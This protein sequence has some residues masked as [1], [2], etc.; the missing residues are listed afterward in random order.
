MRRIN[1]SEMAVAP[2]WNHADPADDQPDNGDI[3]RQH[4]QRELHESRERGYREGYAQ[5]EKKARD[6]VISEADASTKRQEQEFRR[7]QGEL[8]T[9]RKRLDML[10]DSLSSALE[11]QSHQVEEVAVGIAYAAVAKF[12]GDRY[13]DRDLM[14]ALVGH[15]LTHV[16]E[17]V[18]SVHVS[19]QDFE[20]VRDV[21]TVRIVSDARLLPGQCTLETR[22]GHY[23]TGLD[24]RLELL[25][26]A[27][28]SGL[29]QHRNEERKP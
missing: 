10:F 18:D 1:S 4:Q 22:L 20:Q 26:T 12:L 9:S 6:Q 17:R 19:E 29:A 25:K 21:G 23:E 28:L 14:Q 8:E 7:L 27:L 2:L 5:G 13:A 11:H 15:A 3:L 24:V 16:G